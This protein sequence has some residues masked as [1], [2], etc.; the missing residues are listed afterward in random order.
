MYGL[1]PH[2]LVLQAFHERILTHSEVTMHF[3]N[4]D[5]YDGGGVFFRYRVPI[6]PDDTA[7]ALQARVNKQE[8]RWQW[9]VTNLVVNGKIS[10]QPDGTIKFP[11]GYWEYIAHMASLDNQETLPD[12]NIFF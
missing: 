8:H 4:S 9:W 3:I 10:L 5:K 2:K 6:Y 12:P 11:Q 7:E 1:A